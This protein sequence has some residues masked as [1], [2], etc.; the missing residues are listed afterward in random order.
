MQLG[1]WRRL[2]M[3]TGLV[4][5]LTAVRLEQ[6]GAVEIDALLD[7]MQQAYE[8]TPAI[9]ADFV[10]VATLSALNREQTSSGRVYIQKPH[11]IRWEYSQPASQTILYKDSD[12]RIYT[13]NRKQVLQSVVDA[14]NR[15][16]VALLFLA[17]IGT[18]R[19]TFIVT[20]LPHTEAMVT[21]LQLQPRSPQAGFTK[22]DIGVSQK[23]AL[24]SSLTIHDHIGNRTHIRFANLQLQETLPATLFELKLPPDTEIITQPNFSKQK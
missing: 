23:S 20:E 7:R 16:N 14:D 6:A 19:E 21:R 17:G 9:S 1:R 13:P 22:L 5:L 11:S 12:L 8:S 18:L 4:L 24:I 2:M 3:G 15:S 10:Q